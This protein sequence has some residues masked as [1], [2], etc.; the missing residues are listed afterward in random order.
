MP[1][2]NTRARSTT[3]SAG[4]GPLVFGGKGKI[5]ETLPGY[6]MVGWS[7]QGPFDELPARGRSR[8][9]SSP[10]ARWGRRKARGSC[11][12]RPAA[13]LRTT[14]WERSWASRRSRRSTGGGIYVAGFDWLTGRDVHEVEKPIFADLERKGLLLRHESYRTAIPSAGAATRSSSSAWRMSGSC[15]ASRSGR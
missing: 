3:A 8:T 4:V 5:L 10:G 11:I 7:Y 9:W 6:E 13:G 14:S 12:S 15:A 1:A 2:S